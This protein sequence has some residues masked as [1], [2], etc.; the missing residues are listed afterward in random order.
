MFGDPLN[1]VILE[2]SFMHD[3]WTPKQAP[4]NFSFYLY[5]A[6]TCLSPTKSILLSGGLELTLSVVTAS[7]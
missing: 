2:Y 6:G 7:T 5:R 1:N 3:T 4:P